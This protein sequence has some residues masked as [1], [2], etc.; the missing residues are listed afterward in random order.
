MKEK[1]EEEKAKAI[2]KV[3]EEEMQKK[4]KA[5]EA[6]MKNLQ[7]IATCLNSYKASMHKFINSTDTFFSQ[8]DLEKTHESAKADAIAMVWNKN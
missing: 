7:M 3:K 8:G 2:A 6:D 1:S 4:L 5:A